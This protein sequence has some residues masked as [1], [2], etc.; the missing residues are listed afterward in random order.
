MSHSQETTCE[1]SPKMG[2][3]SKDTVSACAHQSLCATEFCHALAYRVVKN[4]LEHHES[5]TMAILYEGP[6]T[7]NLVD[8]S[9]RRKLIRIAIESLRAGTKIYRNK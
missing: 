1:Y 4:L 7:I 5:F 2:E 9:G 6:A 3:P 8:V